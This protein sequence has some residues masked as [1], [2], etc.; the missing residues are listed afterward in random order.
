[1]ALEYVVSS[2]TEWY[3]DVQTEYINTTNI[4]RYVY[5]NTPTNIGCKKPIKFK[6][7]NEYK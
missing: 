4:Y 3:T 6:A 2:S 7:Q 1:M 5:K